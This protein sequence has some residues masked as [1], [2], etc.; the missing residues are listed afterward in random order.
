MACGEGKPPALP[1]LPRVRRLFQPRNTS[2]CLQLRSHAMA[3]ALCWEGREAGLALYCELEGVMGAP[4]AGGGLRSEPGSQLGPAAERPLGHKKPCPLFCFKQLCVCHSRDTRDLL[5]PCISGLSINQVSFIRQPYPSL[6]C[7][8]M[9]V[10][11]CFA[12]WAGL[13]MG[14]V[15]STQL[16]GSEETGLTPLLRARELCRRAGH[17]KNELVYS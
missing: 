1:G 3:I 16:K 12:S 13:E 5:G 14:A 15:S 9:C 6:W 4:C 10:R 2:R 7:V 11:L 17:L 8:C